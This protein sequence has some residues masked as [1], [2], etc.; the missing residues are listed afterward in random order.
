MRIAFTII[1]DGLHH[2]Q[3]ND[4]AQFM[5][6]N[7]DH[8]IVIEGLSRAG[9]STA[10]CK[11][12]GLHVRSKDGTHEFM[13]DLC[14][15]YSNVHYYSPGIAWTS[16]DKQVNEAIMIAKLLTNECYLWQVDC[17]EQWSAESLK[18]AEIEL[19]NSGSN[20]GAFQFNHYICQD[21]LGRQLVGKGTWGDNFNTRL[22]LWKGEKF[23]THEPPVIEGQKQIIH[24]SQ[25]YEHYSYYFEKDILFKTA[26]YGYR[27][28]HKNW[29]KLRSYTGT[30]PQPATLLL[31]KE[32]RHVPKHSFIDQL[33]LKP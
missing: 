26:Y 19:S 12:I 31:G 10:W 6:K 2:L 20:V 7:F 5:V 25:R 4:F 32:N 1:Y 18:Q 22:W 33:T 9:G 11:N 17:D 8:W 27:S 21:G 30:L 29:S 16:K 3:H 28:L 24:L 13:V 23:L 14:E 15:K